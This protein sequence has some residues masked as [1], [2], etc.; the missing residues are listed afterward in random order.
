MQKRKLGKSDISVAPWALGTNVF[1]W[2]IDEAASFKILDAFTDAGFN[3]VDTADVYSRW[4]EGNEGGE[5]EIIIGRWLKNKGKRD[6]IIL[7][8]K[9]GS[10]MGQGKSLRKGYILTA[11]EESLRRL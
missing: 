4:K 3:L 7:A 9:V 5:S 8:T 11:V 1:G 2:T 10:D 6:K